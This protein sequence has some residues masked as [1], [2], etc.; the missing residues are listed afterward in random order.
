MSDPNFYSGHETMRKSIKFNN[1]VKPRYTVLRFKTF[2]KCGNSKCCEISFHL[3][4]GAYD[5]TTEDPQDTPH[6][7]SLPH[8]L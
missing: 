7:G 1:T 5:I 6:G 3:D 2:V 8:T 4:F